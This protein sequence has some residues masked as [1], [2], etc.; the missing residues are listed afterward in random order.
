MNIPLT[1]RTL[2]VTVMFVQV[3]LW[4]YPAYNR[5]PL[6][7]HTSH[8]HNIFGVAWLPDNRHIVTGEHSSCSLRG[9]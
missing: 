8:T 4:S 2:S 1:E 9:I 7:I 3:L 6:R 5:K